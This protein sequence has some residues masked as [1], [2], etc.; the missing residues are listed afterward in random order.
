MSYKNTLFLKQIPLKHINAL[1]NITFLHP[2]DS[3]EI[4]SIVAPKG[5]LKSAS[6]VRSRQTTRTT[7]FDNPPPSASPTELKPTLN[8]PGGAGDDDAPPVSVL[9]NLFFLSLA[10]G[11]TRQW[12]PNML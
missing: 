8:V 1:S 6:R 11:N 3:S 9:A 5:R 7:G 12:K 10:D 2:P 4:Q